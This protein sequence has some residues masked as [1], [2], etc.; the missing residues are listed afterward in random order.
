MF[1]F[2]NRMTKIPKDEECQC[3]VTEIMDHIYSCQFLNEK[4]PE[5]MINFIM[6]SQ[7]EVFGRMETNLERRNQ[8]RAKNSFPCNLS[9][10]LNC[11]Q[12]RFG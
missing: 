9:D 1:E 3:G 11:Y 10:P 2:R 4:K 12:S 6:E 5:I 8:I 7:I